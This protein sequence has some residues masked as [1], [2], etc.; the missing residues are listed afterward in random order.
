GSI[1]ENFQTRLDRRVSSML[2][3]LDAE[4]LVR[5]LARVH[6]LIENDS[7]LSLERR[8]SKG[9][10]VRVKQGALQG[11]EGIIIRR[12]KTTRLLIAVSYLQQGV[13]IQIDDFMVEPL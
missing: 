1:E 3:V 6:R 10:K 7:P 9:D 4:Q 12:E 2:P 5:D 11:L 13:S 8:L